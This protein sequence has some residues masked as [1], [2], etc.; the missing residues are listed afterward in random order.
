M[1]S[2]YPIRIPQNT[3]TFFQQYQSVTLLL[4]SVFFSHLLSVVSSWQPPAYIYLQLTMLLEHIHNNLSLRARILPDKSSTFFF[5]KQLHSF[6]S[7]D[8]FFLPP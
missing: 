1:L 6:F 8:L 7:F 4:C 3:L 5:K 2:A